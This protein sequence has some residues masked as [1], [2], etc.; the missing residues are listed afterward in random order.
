V[1]SYETPYDEVPEIKDYLAFYWDQ[2]D[3]WLEEDDEVFG[4]PHDPYSRFDILNSSREVRV[5]LAGETV[6]QTKR[7]RFLFGT[8]ARTRY[9]IPKED[10]R[11]ELLAATDHHTTCTYKGRASYWSVQVGDKVYENAVWGYPAPNPEEA[12]QIRGYLCFYNE[13]MDAITVDDEPVDL[14]RKNF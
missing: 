11:I 8:G 9:Y 14:D 13:Q 5:V 4:H 12:E 6:A 7:A 10:V 2:V 3:H 1:W